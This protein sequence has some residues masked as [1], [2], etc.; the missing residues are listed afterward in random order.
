MKI[1]NKCLA[2]PKVQHYFRGRVNDTPS[3]F[4]HRE[5]TQTRGAQCGDRFSK[6]EMFMDPH[7][8]YVN[9]SKITKLISHKTAILT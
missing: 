5:Q 9:L 1:S 7:I 2:G 8:S 6:S 4:L 3:A